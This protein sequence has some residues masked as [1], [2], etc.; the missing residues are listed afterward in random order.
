MRYFENSTND[1]EKRSSIDRRKKNS[2]LFSK[3]LLVGR[4]TKPRR[5][6]DRLRPQNVDRYS[7]KILAIIIGILALS[8]LDALFT[9]FLIDNGAKEVNPLMAYYLDLSPELFVFI[10]Y[11]LTSAAV[12]LIL[13]C[14]DFYMFNSKFKARILFFLL[15]LPFILVIPWQLHLIFFGF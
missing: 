15:P 4:R 3:Y 9:L 12:V 10:K 8:M 13:F 6:A 11:F 14:K 2:P 5:E 1:L 7:S